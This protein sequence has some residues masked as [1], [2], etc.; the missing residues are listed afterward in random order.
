MSFRENFVATA[1]LIWGLISKGLN[2]KGLL[3]CGDFQAMA[4][5]A[6]FGI[7]AAGGFS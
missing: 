7:D 5:I 1:T 2:S 6:S 3:V 4:L